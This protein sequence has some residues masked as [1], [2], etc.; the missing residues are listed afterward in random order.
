VSGTVPTYFVTG[1]NSGIGL[2]TARHLVEHG[3]H[4]VLAVR[5][6]ARGRQA[7]A[8]LTGPG[9]TSIVEL[10]LA[11]LDVVTRCADALLD[12]HDALAGLV[13]NAGIMGGPALLTAQG[14][15]R[16]MGTNHLGHVALVSALWPLLEHSAA[17]VVMVS[18]SEA[19]GGQLS[20]SS[21]PDQLLNPMPY[22]GK[23][24][25]RNSKQAN[26]L[27]A[28]E[29]H[30]RCRTT[31]SQVSVVA[32]HPGAV[33]TNLLARQLDRG[34]RAWLGTAST[35]VT[36][37]LLPSPDAG[38]RAILTAL[39][40]STPSGA[41]VAPAGTGQLRG[42]PR[43][44]AVYASATDPAVA[45]RVWELTQQAL[46]EATLNPTRKAPSCRTEELPSSSQACSSSRS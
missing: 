29:L 30:R 37:M 11:D 39:H 46:Q 18:S 44:A 22:D 38:A 28:Q 40:P 25:Y 10:D 32:A 14:F 16:Q 7:A 33:A 34:G 36:S 45:A 26:L 43:S 31:G 41:F 17:R 13:C 5:D 4:V 42:N 12:R 2:A 27:F 9:S 3:A 19:R 15:E 1:A 24:T 35:V 8:R 20:A 23:Q 21:T 6:V